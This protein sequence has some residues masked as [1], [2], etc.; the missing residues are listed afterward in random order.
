MAMIIGVG[1]SQRKLLRD[2]GL[3]NYTSNC[4]GLGIL[5]VLTDCLAP[6][7]SI[8]AQAGQQ[9]VANAASTFVDGQSL[10]TAHLVQFAWM[11]FSSHNVSCSFLH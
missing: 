8:I 4:V 11:R 1:S 9:D 2:I 6:T 3:Q 7:T 5:H 10:I